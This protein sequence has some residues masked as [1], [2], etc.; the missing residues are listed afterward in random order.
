MKKKFKIPMICMVLLISV[1]VSSFSVSASSYSDQDDQWMYNDNNELVYLCRSYVEY[2]DSTNSVEGSS[3]VEDFYNAEY[4]I[5]AYVN[6]TAYYGDGT[7]GGITGSVSFYQAMYLTDGYYT[8]IE[9]ICTIPDGTFM[10]RV[11]QTAVFNQT[12]SYDGVTYYAVPSYQSKTLSCE[13][14]IIGD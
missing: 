8:P 4:D 11:E 12:C 2:D 13:I 9:S 1:L 5:P 10:H 3:W 14:I 6:M 7:P